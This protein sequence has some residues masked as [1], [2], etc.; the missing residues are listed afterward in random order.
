MIEGAAQSPWWSNSDGV[1]A[2]GISNMSMG[3]GVSW[4]RV[5]GV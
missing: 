3:S 4:F 1:G 5:K 2:G